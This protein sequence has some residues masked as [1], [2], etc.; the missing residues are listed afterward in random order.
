[1]SPK[2]TSDLAHRRQSAKGL[3]AYSPAMTVATV[4]ENVWRKVLRHVAFHARKFGRN[5]NG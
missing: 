4:M 3:G 1:M 5:P 2:G